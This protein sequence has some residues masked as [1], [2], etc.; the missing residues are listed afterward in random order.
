MTLKRPI[1]SPCTVIL[2]AAGKGRRFGGDIPKQ[3]Q[4]VNNYPIVYHTVQRLLHH[5]LIEAILP[6]IASGD[7]AL[8]AK[9]VKDC[10]KNQKILPPIYGGVER[11][12]SVYNALQSLRCDPDDWVAVHDGA[13]PLISNALLDRLFAARATY[14][15][16]IPALPL[17]DT[18][19]ETT[20]DKTV[21]KTIDRSQL[22]RIQTPQ[23]FRFG[24]LK[25]AYDQAIK[26]RFMATDDASIV[27]QSDTPVGLIPGEEQNI[28]ITHRQDRAW[29][30]F[31]LEC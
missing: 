17:S 22:R 8:W 19:K 10:N 4:K 20:D 29:M 2:L 25:A 9:V 12:D 7:D 15:A 3:Y 28:K 21:T 16:L 31:Y 6:V 24:L 14:N 1:V 11:R 26:A 5:P 23:V 27:E 30:A 18:I 13:R